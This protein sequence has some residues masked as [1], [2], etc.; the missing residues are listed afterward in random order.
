MMPWITLQRL[1]CSSAL[2]W[3]SSPAAGSCGKSCSTTPVR[4]PPGFTR[5]ASLRRGSDAIHATCSGAIITPDS[6]LVQDFNVRFVLRQ[7]SRPPSSPS[8]STLLPQEKPYERS[9]DTPTS[10]PIPSTPLRIVTYHLVIISTPPGMEH[11]PSPDYMLDDQQGQQHTQQQPQHSPQQ[12]SLSSF[13]NLSATP[14]LSW[15]DA[16]ASGHPTL[17]P[18][19]HQ[20]NNL[21]QFGSLSHAHPVRP[22]Y[23]P[24][25]LHTPSNIIHE[26]RPIKRL[27]P[28][29]ARRRHGPAVVLAEPLQ[30]VVVH[31]VF[32]IDLG[33]NA[34]EHLL[35][36][37]SA[38]NPSNA[39]RWSRRSRWWPA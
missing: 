8:P 35:R 39:S 30:Y 1:L 21:T 29:A 27:L 9:L 18:L 12:G 26:K 24:S 37:R 7:V 17:L 38:Q 16:P 36:Q 20:K 14:S 11:Q 15:L 6:P 33:L 19:Q 32:L 4:L 23:T 34:S 22:I 13:A 5:K 25:T 3:P 2:R 10:V 31:H 28:R